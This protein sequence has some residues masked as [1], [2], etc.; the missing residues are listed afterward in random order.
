MLVVVQI[1]LKNTSLGIGIDLLEYRDFGHPTSL[2]IVDNVRNFY[3]KEHPKFDMIYCVGTFNFGTLEDMYMNF[4]IFTKMAPR[5]FGHARQA[6]KM[7]KEA[8]KCR[9][10]IL[11]MDI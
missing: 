6:S 8:K 10:S 5:I 7:I 9:I 3:I 1:N 2:D 4:D 11:S